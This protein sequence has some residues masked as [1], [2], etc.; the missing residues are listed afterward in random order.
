MSYGTEYPSGQPGSVALAV[1]KPPQLLAVR[2]AR[3]A[4]KFSTLNTSLQ[5]LKTLI[6]CHLCFQQKSKTQH[7]VSLY[8]EEPRQSP[9]QK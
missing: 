7:Q 2:A 8:E 6:C 4:E 1:S 9:S 5:Q 3:E